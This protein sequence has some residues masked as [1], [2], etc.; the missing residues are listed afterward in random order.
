MFLISLI[1]QMLAK[2][3]SLLKQT[4]QNSIAPFPFPSSIPQLLPKEAEE[5]VCDDMNF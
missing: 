2:K 5:L 3:E 1:A 4:T